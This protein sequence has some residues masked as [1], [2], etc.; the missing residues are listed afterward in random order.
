MTLESTRPISI[1][2]A[3]IGGEGGGVLSAWL[4]NAATAAGFPVQS[5]SV[6]GVA[7]RTG[8]T[9][10]YIEIYPVPHSE[11][12]GKE[13]VLALTPAP[14][15]IDMM[16]ASELVEA[17]RAVQNGF[18]SPERTTLIASTH[19]IY[20]VSE[21]TVSADGRYEADLIINA[22]QELAQHT[23][24]RDFR[25]LAKECGSVINAVLLGAMTGSGKLPFDKAL[26]S[27]SVDFPS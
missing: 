2:I 21:K 8:A 9:T 25:M 18:V 13:P 12:A 3:A 27:L 14:G 16:V 24:L 4:V 17:G 11:L 19:R 22:A 7:Q 26:F 20:A 15:E 6:P 10:Y 5:T 23:I 1:L